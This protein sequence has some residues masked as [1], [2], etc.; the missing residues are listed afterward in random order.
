[1]VTGNQSTSSTKETQVI[2]DEGNS[3]FNNRE[4]IVDTRQNLFCN[5][6]QELEKQTVNDNKGKKFSTLPRGYSY[7]LVKEVAQQNPHECST[8]YLSVCLI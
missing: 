7:N 8:V 4:L 6:E 2:E 3:R 1:M 5:G